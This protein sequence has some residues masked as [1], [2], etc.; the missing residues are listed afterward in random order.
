MSIS[1][2]GLF[3]LVALALFAFW[4]VM[5]VDALRRSAAKWEKA[6]QN[7]LLWVGVIVF[8]QFLGAL[9]YLIIARP[10]LEQANTG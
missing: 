10:A 9:L 4:V 8:L 5:L 2:F 7:Q 1:V 6:S 3:G